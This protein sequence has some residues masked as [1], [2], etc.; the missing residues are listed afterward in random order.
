MT[1]GFLGS[2]LQNTLGEEDISSLWKDVT[3]LLCCQSYKD[4][5]SWALKCTLMIGQ[6]TIDSL[7]RLKS[8]HTKS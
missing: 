4:A 5:L 7:G 6:S 2:Y 8:V 1:R 3:G